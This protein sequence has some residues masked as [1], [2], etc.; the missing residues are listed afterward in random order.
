MAAVKVQY[1]CALLEDK[2]AAVMVCA[3]KFNYA[4]VTT[5]SGTMIRAKKARGATS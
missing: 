5:V 2:K 3:D 4:A 1:G